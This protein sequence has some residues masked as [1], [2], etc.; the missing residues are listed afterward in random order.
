MYKETVQSNKK[1]LFLILAV[2]VLGLVL[3]G[4]L[5]AFHLPY[6]SVWE[7]VLFLALG[8]LTYFLIRFNLSD[9]KYVFIEN[10]LIFQKKAGHE[11]L[12]LLTVE[13]HQIETFMPF[14]SYR[15]ESKIPREFTHIIKKNFN[16][17]LAWV[18]TFHQDGNLNK[19]VF[20]PT[21]TLVKMIQ[22]R[23]SSIASESTSETNEQE[24]KENAASDAQLH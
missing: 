21:P 13:I 16:N 5:D 20:E 24:V 17:K 9:Y 15:E 14:E 3:F 22:K 1:T 4:I 12:V 19:V 8:V 18:C 10:E 7:L 6:R 2:I 11:D 23:L